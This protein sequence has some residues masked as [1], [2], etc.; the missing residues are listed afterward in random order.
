MVKK[1]SLNKYGLKKKS[2]KDLVYTIAHSVYHNLQDKATLALIRK[3]LTNV[4][5]VYVIVHNQSKNLYVGSSINLARGLTD[6]V[7]NQNSNLLIQRAIN[8][9][10]LSYFSIYILELLPTDGYL[11]KEELSLTL[12]KMEKKYLDSFKDKYKINSNVLQSGSRNIVVT[13]VLYSNGY[14][15]IN[16]YD[17]LVEYLDSLISKIDISKLSKAN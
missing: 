17:K 6:H 16:N 14:I 1:D 7:Y 12:I 4:G 8:K 15:N 5:G 9:Y 13:F 10:G 2:E 3:N 11:T